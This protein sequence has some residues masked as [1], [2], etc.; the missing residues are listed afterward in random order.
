MARTKKPR[1]RRTRPNQF[2]S[3]PFRSGN[4]LLGRG[5]SREGAPSVF[6]AAFPGAFSGRLFRTMGGHAAQWD[7]KFWGGGYKLKP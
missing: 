6:G 1:P 4:R 2:E 7:D 3:I 5:R